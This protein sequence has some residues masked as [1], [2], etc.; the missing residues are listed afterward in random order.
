MTSP[1][2]FFFSFFRERPYFA[3]MEK[4]DSEGDS[5]QVSELVPMLT[6]M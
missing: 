4:V 2:P 5:P 1:G 6:P 3:L